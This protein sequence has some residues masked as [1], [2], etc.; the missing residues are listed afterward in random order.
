MPNNETEDV[1]VIA[2]R[3][4]DMIQDDDRLNH[5]DDNEFDTIWEHIKDHYELK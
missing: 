2:H 3:L 1:Y 4:M 5:L